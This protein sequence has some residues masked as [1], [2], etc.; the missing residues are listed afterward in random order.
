MEHDPLERK[1]FELIPESAAKR[2]TDCKGTGWKPAWAR[3]Y[4]MPM[5]AAAAREHTEECP[6]P[7]G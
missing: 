4:Q 1:C 6:W 3:S 5:N 2:R 7:C